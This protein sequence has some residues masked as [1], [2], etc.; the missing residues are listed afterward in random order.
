MSPYLLA[1]PAYVSFSGGRTSAFMLRR[2]LDA[3]SEVEVLFANTGKEREETLDF[4][5]ECGSRWGV[6]IHWLER[7]PGGDAVEVDYASAARHGEPFER[8]I[9]ERGYVPNPAAPFCSTE[10]KSRVCRD[11]MRQRGHDEWDAAVGIRADEPKRVARL[12]GRK[13]EGGHVVMPLAEAGVCEEDVLRFWRAQPFDLRLHSHEGNCDLCFK[14]AGRK[15]LGLID[16]AP[17]R[18]DWWAAQ[19]QA[20]KTRWRIDRPTYGALVGAVRK[21]VRLPLLDEGGEP[22]DICV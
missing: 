14:K 8:L 1:A 22:C 16:R 11:F 2:I 17:D 13:V 15:L 6:A 10:L 5:A 20:T 19:E 7:G 12:R 4:V 9:Q 21:Q 3:G 18:A